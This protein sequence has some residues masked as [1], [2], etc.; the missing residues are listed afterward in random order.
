M[1]HSGIDNRALCSRS[2]S[3]LPGASLEI[4]YAVSCSNALVCCSTCGSSGCVASR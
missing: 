2:L 3:G 4:S 1:I